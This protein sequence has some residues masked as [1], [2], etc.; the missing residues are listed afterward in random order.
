M[1]DADRNVAEALQLV[2]SESQ[3]IP[4]DLGSGIRIAPGSGANRFK[5]TTSTGANLPGLNPMSNVFDMI[6]ARNLEKE[7]GRLT[8]EEREFLAGRRNRIV[9]TPP[10]FV[11]NVS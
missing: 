3:N 10:R 7:V 9:G 8:D 4:I 11:T 6:D 5:F 1:Q 2:P